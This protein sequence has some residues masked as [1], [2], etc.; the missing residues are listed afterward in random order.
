MGKLS[1]RLIAIVAPVGLSLALLLSSPAITVRAQQP[2]A[3]P[4]VHLL[5]AWRVGIAH[6]QGAEGSL[7]SSPTPTQVQQPAAT[8]T[9]HAHIFLPVKPP[10]GWTAE[11]WAD[12]RQ[13]CQEIANRGHSNIPL[14]RKQFETASVCASFGPWPPS[15]T[16]EPPYPQRRLNSSPMPT[17]AAT[18]QPQ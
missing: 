3:T 6:G 8:P 2:T 18:P 7:Q 1:L 9:V 5:P 10:A 14:T 17:A 13:K 16:R 11:R 15:E 12:F 4:A